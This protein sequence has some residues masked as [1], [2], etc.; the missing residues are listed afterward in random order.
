MSSLGFS[1]EGI[2]QA[3]TA[4]MMKAVGGIGKAMKA[5]LG[6]IGTL[7][8]VLEALGI[9]QPIFDILNALFSMIGMAFMPIVMQIV[10]M[11]TP[12]LPTF[13]AL[14]I[15]LTPLI[16]IIVN[17]LV[18]LQALSLILPYINAGIVLLT[19]ALNGVDWTAVQDYIKALPGKMVEWIG[20]GLG[21]LKD[22]FTGLPNWIVEQLGD[23]GD[24]IKRTIKSW[25]GL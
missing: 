3:L 11:L 22:F 23:M 21:T 15:A 24:A 4:P 19:D 17:V 12:F 8:S 13:Q 1:G 18:P 25:F 14:M 2:A 7:M 5:S 16:G 10:N 20:N 6:A 9:A